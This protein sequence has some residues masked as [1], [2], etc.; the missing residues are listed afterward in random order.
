MEPQVGLGY[1]VEC[2]CQQ[3]TPKDMGHIMHTLWH[4]K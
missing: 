2:L 1:V 3:E 4:S